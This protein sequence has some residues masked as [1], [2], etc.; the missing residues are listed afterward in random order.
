LAFIGFVVFGTLIGAVV[1]ML[2]AGRAG[3]WSGSM[4]GG[5]GGALLSGSVGRLDG[6]RGI[7]DSG[8]FSMALVGAF[9]VVAAYNL[10]AAGRRTRALALE[11]PKERQP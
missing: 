9:V 11:Q 5:A 6:L 3:S 1:R 7:H 2:A 8:G 10:M 4:L